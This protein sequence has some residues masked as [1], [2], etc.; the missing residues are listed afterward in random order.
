MFRCQVEALDFKGDVLV[1]IST[2]GRSRNLAKAFDAARRKGILAVSM[3]GATGG[4]MR[5]LSDLCLRV[6]PS[7]VQKIQEG[8][9]VLGHI[10]CMLIE[11]AM[12]PRES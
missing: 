1:R 7:E 9:I 5:L 12:F 2:T 4:D 6:P 8:H 3:A 11:R 10:F